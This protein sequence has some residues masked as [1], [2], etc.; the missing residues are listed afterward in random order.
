[1]DI[2]IIVIT[3]NHQKFIKRCLKSIN[4]QIFSGSIEILIADDNSEDRTSHIIK[5]YI[6]DKKKFKL[7]PS[8]KSQKIDLCG[9]KNGRHNVIN[10][11]RLVKGDYIAICDGDDF[12]I[13]K[14]KLML[15]FDILKQNNYDI[16]FESPTVHGHLKSSKIHCLKSEDVLTSSILAK[17]SI[18]NQFLY[19]SKYV[20]VGDYI[21]QLSSKNGGFAFKKNILIHYEINNFN[22]WTKK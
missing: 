13:N 12:L 6:K 2:S 17:R 21:W 4:D 10:L 5:N 11:L 15:Q 22:S 7:I 19:V 9:T 16:S 18:F 14:K 8:N 3:Y 20:P 1:M